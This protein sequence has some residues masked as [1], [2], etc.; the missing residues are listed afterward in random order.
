MCV[1]LVNL[2]GWTVWWWREFVFGTSWH[3]AFSEFSAWIAAG[4][5][6]SL[7]SE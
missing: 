4:T 6:L 3:W 1:L 7:L 5:D 2:L